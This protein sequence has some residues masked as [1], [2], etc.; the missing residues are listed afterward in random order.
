MRLKEGLKLVN[1][2]SGEVAFGD[3]NEDPIA[4]L[5]RRK[6]SPLSQN[7][8]ARSREDGSLSFLF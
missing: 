7:L 4:L 2:R 1:L 5:K 8:C 3:G 6:M